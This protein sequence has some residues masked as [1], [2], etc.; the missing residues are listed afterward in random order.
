MNL[1][2]LVF[3]LLAADGGVGRAQVFGPPLEVLAYRLQCPAGTGQET[4]IDSAAEV[5]LHV[6]NKKGKRAGPAVLQGFDGKPVASRDDE[7]TCRVAQADALA[8]SKFRSDFTGCAA[9]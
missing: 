9:K 5:A 8:R 2:A 4:S 7:Q 1:G 6:C 3:V